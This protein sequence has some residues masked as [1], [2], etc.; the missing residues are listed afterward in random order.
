MK[1]FDPYLG[2]FHGS[3]LLMVWN[4]RDGFVPLPDHIPV[5]IIFSPAEIK[6]AEFMSGSWVSFGQHR[7]PGLSWPVYNETSDVSE[8][9]DTSLAHVTG[10]RKS[11]C[12]FWDTLDLLENPST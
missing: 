9:L 12:D 4:L 8:H 3:E 7:N 2:V 1:H 6:L 5:P 11:I 10:L